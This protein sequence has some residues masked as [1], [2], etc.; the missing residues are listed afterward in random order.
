M[1]S[2][3]DLPTLLRLLY[4]EELARVEDELFRSIL[5]SRSLTEERVKLLARVNKVIA[6]LRYV[7]LVVDGVNRDVESLQSY[8]SAT[9]RAC[10]GASHTSFS[11]SGLVQTESAST[12][13][14]HCSPPRASTAGGVPVV[15]RGDG[16]QEEAL[17]KFSRH[18]V[19]VALQDLFG[20]LATI[21]ASYTA[22]SPHVISL[23]A[24]NPV[25]L[26]R[27]LES[28]A[29][30]VEEQFAELQNRVKYLHYF[31]VNMDI[32]LVVVILGSNVWRSTGY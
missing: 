31:A 21:N 22:G 11:G 26:S 23:P 25:S 19:R 20:I 16:N 28:L 10:I 5:L 30:S 12:S 17:G 9:P 4:R 29:E 18:E 13:P 6:R 1:Q 3:Q 2:F 14:H 27:D 24:I 32:F 15:A 8:S 7:F